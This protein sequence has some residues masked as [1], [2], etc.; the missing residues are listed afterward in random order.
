[1]TDSTVAVRTGLPS[2][3]PALDVLER[4]SFAVDRLSRRRFAHWVQAENAVLLVAELD[5]RLAG[6]GLVLLHK[7]TRLARLY[8]LAVSELARGHGLGRILLEAM[9]KQAAD[10]GRLFMRLEVA[11]D[12]QAAVALYQSAG[13]SVFGV[14]NDYYQDHQD[15]LRMQKRIRYVPAS[16]IRRPAPWYQQTTPFTCGPAALMMAMA[17]LDSAVPLEQTLELD[18]WREATTIFMTRGHGGCH[19]IGL[20]LAAKKRGFSAEVCLNRH[21][22]LFIEGVRDAGKKAILAVVDGQFRDRAQQQG[23]PLHYHDVNQ[24]DIAGWLGEGAA[25]LV[26][27]STYRMDSRKAPHWVMVSA[28]DEEC[29]YVHDPDPVDE[30]TELDCRYLPIARADFSRMSLFGKEKLQTAVVLRKAPADL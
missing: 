7:G 4:A 21:T 18:I 12:N 16:L 3:V 6:Y 10:R 14:Y 9:E 28:I 19:P 25:V 23:V 1:M 20:A 13:Y 29:L 17:S 27:I 2:D 11:R 8:S 24:N 26:L 22:P 30:Q 15:A 5:G